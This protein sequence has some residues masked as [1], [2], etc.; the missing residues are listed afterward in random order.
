MCGRYL[1]F[2]EKQEIEEHF[3]LES[4]NN[5]VFLAN[6]NVCPG[7]INPVVLQPKPNKMGIGSLRWGL[8]PDWAENPQIAYKMINARTESIF[9]KKSFQKAILRQRCLIPANGFYEWKQ[10]SSKE[11]QAFY[12][13]HPSQKLISFAGIYSF[14]KN[15]IQNTLLWT[16]SILTTAS[17][18]N[19]IDLHE[20]MPVCISQ[21]D[22][23]I[24]LNPLQNDAKHIQSFFDSELSKDFNYKPIS[25]K[26]TEVGLSDL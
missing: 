12:I 3:D 25:K 4:D 24:W 7:T 1:H 13:F 5:D 14:W 10:L 23:A 20:R 17:K 9:E 21:K 19:M 2:S 26:I 8:V 18:G 15:P 22:Y 16:F 6:F 11:K